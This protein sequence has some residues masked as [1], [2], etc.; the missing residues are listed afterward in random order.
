MPQTHPQTNQVVNPASLLELGLPASSSQ[1]TID[2]AIAQNFRTPLRLYASATPDALLNI[3][4]SQ[5]QIGNG[6]GLSVSPQSSSVPS[7]AASTINFQTG[8]TTGGTISMSLPTTT[9]GNFR[10]AA[11]TLNSSGTLVVT[12]SAE[13]ASVGALANAGTLFGSGQPIGWIDLQATAATAYK[14]AGSATS[15]IENSVGGTSRIV[16]MGNGS[17]GGGSA[18]AIAANVSIPNGATSISTTFSSSFSDTSYI[19]VVGLINTTDA[20]PQFQPI[21][22]VTKTTSGFTAKW[23]SP[24][25]SANY[26]LSYFCPTGSVISAQT[27]QNYLDLVIQGSDPSAPSAGNFRI[28]AKS[29]GFYQIDS[30]SVVKPISDVGVAEFD[31]GNSG[32]AKNIDWSNGVT[33]KVTLTANCT[34]TMSNPQASFTYVFKVIQD[35]VGSRTATWPANV[36]WPSGVAPIITTTATRYDL[37]TLYYD[38]TNYLGAYTQ[39]YS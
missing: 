36:K 25:D 8:A 15:V 17:G 18:T 22:V 7:F 37:I 30:S 13:A 29:G 23:N 10:R 31:N 27:P 9:V 5:V 3:A 21:D 1:D 6:A 19:I 4:A 35:A 33:Q 28:Y 32:A 38:G 39:N 20:N 12:F 24:T 34:F 11:F 14:T 16:S 2:A 26:I